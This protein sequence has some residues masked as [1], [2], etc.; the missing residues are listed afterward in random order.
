MDKIELTEKIAQ[1]IWDKLSSGGDWKQI[2]PAQ[3][4]TY[5]SLADVLIDEVLEAYGY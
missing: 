3:K 4:K 2:N 1:I 5:L